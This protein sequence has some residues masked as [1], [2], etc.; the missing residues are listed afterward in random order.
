MGDHDLRWRRPTPGEIRRTGSQQRGC[1]AGSGCRWSSR[2]RGYGRVRGAPGT[3]RWAPFTRFTGRE[4]TPLTAGLRCYTRKLPSRAV[5][6][7]RARR[8]QGRRVRVPEGAREVFVV[9]PRSWSCGGAQGKRGDP[10]LRG[11]W[12]L[13]LPSGRWRVSVWGRG[14]KCAG[15]VGAGGADR[16]LED[17]QEDGRRNRRLPRNGHSRIDCRVGH[18]RRRH[19]FLSVISGPDAP[20]DYRFDMTLPESGAIVA[21]EDGG[22]AILDGS[23][24]LIESVDAPLGQRRQRQ[25]ASRFLP[26]RRL[27]RDHARRARRR[28]LPGR[29]RA[30]VRAVDPGQQP[31]ILRR[32]SAPRRWSAWWPPPR[33]GP[34]PASAPG[35]S[36]S[37]GV[38]YLAG[39]WPVLGGPDLLSPT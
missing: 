36:S 35:R 18:R 25:R 28:R 3:A 1:R 4:S 32:C 34:P 37:S 38:R 33:H 22:F 23:G 16:R 12:L 13:P 10:P 24:T 17:R 39:A 7:L 31:L 9:A 14:A 21:G 29:G 11:V 19:R 20:T 27:H 30:L 15:Q 5:E 6:G 26:L 8:P 2:R